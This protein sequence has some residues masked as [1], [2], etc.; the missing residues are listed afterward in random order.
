VGSL[1]DS[2]SIECRTT[3]P[4]GKKCGGGVKY[5]EG[6]VAMPG[7]CADSTSNPA[8][9]GGDGFGKTW[10]ATEGTDEPADSTTDGLTNTGN[11]LNNPTDNGS[12]TDTLAPVNN[13]ALRC[14]NMVLYG[15]TNW[16]LP[17]KDELNV[18]YGQKTAVGGFSSTMYWTSTET[19][20]N[21]SWVQNFADGVQYSNYSKSGSYY[22][23][24]IRRY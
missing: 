12:A 10:A 4:I 21:T 9:S 14:F 5:A 19:W 3:T 17:S 24:C 6:Y 7:G 1:I 20:T 13:A 22:V 16:Y 18:L 23:R 2:Y 15:K 11:L 8:C